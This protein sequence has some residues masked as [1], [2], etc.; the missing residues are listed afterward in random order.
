[1]KNKLLSTLGLCKKAGLLVEGFD[2]VAAAVAKGRVAAVITTRDLSPKSRKEM[3]LVAQKNNTDI[4]T[5]PVDM[6]DVWQR[7]GRRAGILGVC[8][9]GFARI[10]RSTL[11]RADEE[12]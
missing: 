2:A 4:L 8:D 5:M 9:A 1:M 12:E 7:L 3:E 6:D 11:A 10:L